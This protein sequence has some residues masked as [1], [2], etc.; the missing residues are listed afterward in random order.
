MSKTLGKTMAIF[1]GGIT[2][3]APERTAAVSSVAFKALIAATLACL[4]T[5]CIAGTFFTK[6]S[7]L[8]G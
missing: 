6:T 2:A 5:A 1:V 7:V 4:L 8:F 3:L